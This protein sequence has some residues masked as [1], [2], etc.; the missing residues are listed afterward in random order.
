MVILPQETMENM[1]KIPFWLLILTDQPNNADQT[2][3]ELDQQEWSL[4][5]TQFRGTAWLPIESFSGLNLSLIDLKNKLLDERKNFLGLLN[6]KRGNNSE[7]RSH[8]LA[9]FSDETDFEKFLV[10]KLSDFNDLQFKKYIPRRISSLIIDRQLLL[11]KI[12]L[13]LDKN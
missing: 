2:D 5:V 6:V 1:P 3:K 9:I 8:I 12:P 13:F 4:N 11:S 10:T 7:T